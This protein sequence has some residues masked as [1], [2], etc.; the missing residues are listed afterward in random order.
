VHFTDYLSRYALVKSDS[1]S[2]LVDNWSTFL[3]AVPIA[4]DRSNMTGLV[5]SRAVT[6]LAVHMQHLLV[7]DSFELSAQRQNRMRRPFLKQY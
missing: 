4:F 7:T 2:I 6:R 3:A 5:G 1:W